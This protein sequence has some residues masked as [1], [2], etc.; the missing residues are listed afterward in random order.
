[1]NR[2]DNLCI[3]KHPYREHRRIEGKNW[4]DCWMRTNCNVFL[5]QSGYYEEQY[6]SCMTFRLDNLKYLEQLYDAQ[7]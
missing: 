5:G 6:C 4:S 3:C 2:L 1:M 7:T